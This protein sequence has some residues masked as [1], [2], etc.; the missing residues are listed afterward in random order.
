MWLVYC[1]SWYKTFDV[2]IICF[3]S[4]FLTRTLY[5]RVAGA[6]TAFF[7][8]FHCV[9]FSSL[10]CFQ[11]NRHVEMF[12]RHVDVTSLTQMQFDA[13]MPL[14]VCWI[15]YR[16]TVYAI[17]QIDSCKVLP[18]NGRMTCMRALNNHN[19]LLKAQEATTTTANS[20]FPP[21]FFILNSKKKMTNSLWKMP[22]MCE[23]ASHLCT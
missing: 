16:W 23:P 6:F 17:R 1:L 13:C 5:L 8:C 11:C 14:C 21:I 18:N 3:M 7:I 15:T 4:L 19:Q 20:I 10:S 22:P 9:R 2:L 12:E